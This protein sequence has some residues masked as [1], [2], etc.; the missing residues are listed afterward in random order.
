MLETVICY[1]TIYR[2]I[3]G[4]L[5]SVMK[6]DNVI[7]RILSIYLSTIISLINIQVFLCY[8]DFD[9]DCLGMNISTIRY[10]SICLYSI[11]RLNYV[12]RNVY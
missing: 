5:W 8:L 2:Y 9:K 1:E 3:F 11:K 4:K 7:L 10:K 6:Y 12:Y